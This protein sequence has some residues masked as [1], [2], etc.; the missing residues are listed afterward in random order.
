[1]QGAREV[2][3]IR[4]AVLNFKNVRGGFS[5]RHG[6]GSSEPYHSLNLGLSGGD[7]AEIVHENRRRLFA[8][9]GLPA[10]RL[11]IAGQIHGVNV[12]RTSDSGLYP[13]IDALVTRSAHLVLCITAADCAVILLADSGARVVGACHSGWRGTV[14][15]IVEDTVEEMQDLGARPEHL[16]AFVSPCISA[17]HFEVG[18]EVAARFSD[19][20]VLE[21]DDWPR[22][23]VD[24]KSAIRDQLLKCGLRA[25]SIE[26]SPHCTFTETDAFFSYR[27]EKGK[28]GRMMGFISLL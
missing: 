7:D 17:D 13:G 23:H 19:Q 11:A 28:T 12:A 21:R 5:L 10:D 9:A 24:L 14:D 25:S 8:M 15:H 27:A 6:G 1:M 16:H 26:I 20:Y 18:H 3:L 2:E 4:P 22:P